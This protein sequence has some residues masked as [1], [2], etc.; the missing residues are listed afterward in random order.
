M[1]W[2][3]SRDLFHRRRRLEGLYGSLR[4]AVGVYGAM[5]D[6]EA[7]Y[8]ARCFRWREWVGGMTYCTSWGGSEAREIVSKPQIVDLLHSKALYSVSNPLPNLSRC[9]NLFPSQ[10][11][12]YSAN[13]SVLTK[14]H[15]PNLSYHRT[16][17]PSC[18]F[19]LPNQPAQFG[20]T[21]SY[22][23]WEQRIDGRCWGRRLGLSWGIRSIV[24]RCGLVWS[25][26]Y[27]PFWDSKWM[28]SSEKAGSS[29]GIIL[30]AGRLDS[31][32]QQLCWWRSE[33][34]LFR[35]LIATNHQQH[36]SFLQDKRYCFHK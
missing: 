1:G 9:P 18:G 14:H 12:S 36:Q 35:Q 6:L 30:S 21:T 3:W 32:E 31:V 22:G 2:A 28:I 17:H 16:K 29:G 34:S 8:L 19:F 7:L 27:E 10:L 26:L 13:S 24:C 25:G 23:C 4:M 33:A 11:F 20:D 5:L 15:S